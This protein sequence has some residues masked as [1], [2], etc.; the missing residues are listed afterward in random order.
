[1]LFSYQLALC[2]NLSQATHL[3]YHA[4]PALSRTFL[5]NSYV[6]LSKPLSLRRNRTY[7]TTGIFW[8]QPLFSFFLIFFMGVISFLYSVICLLNKR[9]LPPSFISSGGMSAPSIPAVRP[10]Y[11]NVSASLSCR[12]QS[13][14]P[15]EHHKYS[16]GIVSMPRSASYL[17]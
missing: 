7:N 6:F 4:V 3:F 13:L 8:C 16:S 9:R 2:C 12:P 17:P 11:Q 15:P 14:Y 5:R 10:Q 1:M